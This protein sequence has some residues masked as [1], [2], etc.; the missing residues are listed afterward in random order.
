[1]LDYHPGIDIAGAERTILDV[2]AF[3]AGWKDVLS[4]VL[5]AVPESRG[6]LLVD[7]LNEPDAFSLTWNTAGGPLSV[8]SPS[9]DPKGFVTATPLPGNARPSLDALYLAALDALYPLCPECVFLVEGGGQASVPGVHWGNGFV[10]DVS[11]A[12]QRGIQTPQSFFEK[13]LDAPWLKQLAL[14]PHIYCPRVS[15]AVDCFRGGCLFDSLDRSF[16]VLTKGQGFC[17]SSSSSSANSNKK[18]TSCHVF[19][20]VIGELGSTLENERESSC[21]SSVVDWVTAT[22]DAASSDRVPYR[23]VFWVRK[24]KKKRE[25]REREKGD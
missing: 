18:G 4:S 16:G 17:S 7:L 22:G 20:A 14:A 19:P 15:G 3:V 1:M 2:D 6:R 12:S 5:E 13:A 9:P 24:K 25:E 11:L 10:S 8:K 23:S 21:M